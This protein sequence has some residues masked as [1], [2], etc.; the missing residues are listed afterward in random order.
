MVQLD[1]ASAAVIV[2]SYFA[3]HEANAQLV[4][5]S[6]LAHVEGILLLPIMSKNV[7]VEEEGR[8]HRKLLGISTS[9]GVDTNLKLSGS[10]VLGEDIAGLS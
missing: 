10:T 9:K 4:R 5:V 7:E 3:R 8:T 2:P 6:T 1:T